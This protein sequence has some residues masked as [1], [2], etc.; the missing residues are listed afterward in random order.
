MRFAAR[1]EKPDADTP[2]AYHAK[3]LREWCTTFPGKVYIHENA[4]AQSLFGVFQHNT[5]VLL[6]DLERYRT[7][8]I[9][10]VYYEA[11]EPGYSGFS[12]MFEILADAMNGKEIN[13]SPQELERILPKTGMRIFCTDPDF[14]LEKY[15]MDPFALKQAKLYCEFWR[16]PTVDLYRRYLDCAFEHEDSMDALMIGFGIAQYGRVSG[17]M[18][19]THLS[20]EAD[21]L[22][23]RRKLWNFME[24]IPLSEDPRAVCRDLILELA[25]KAESS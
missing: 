1:E 16:N 12:D 2:N 22:L 17:I 11:Y 7:L 23:H 8:G 14:P 4:M 9:Q 18:S 19:Y 10:G 21:D 5:S 20:P 25:A 24:D 3:R 6:K 13:Y 15:L